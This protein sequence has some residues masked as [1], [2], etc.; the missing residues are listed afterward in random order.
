M[1]GGPPHKGTLLRPGT[2]ESIDAQ[3][4][5]YNRIVAEICRGIAEAAKLNAGPS[6][7]PGW[8]AVDCPDPASADWLARAVTMENVSA[9]CE[10]KILFLPAGPAYRIEKEVK[11][12]VT[13]IAKTCHYWFDHTSASHRAEIAELTAAMSR[14]APL[15][16]PGWNSASEDW[17]PAPMPSVAT[18]IWMMRAVVACN[19]LARREGTT[20]LVAR[21]SAIDPADAR[22]TAVL[23]QLSVYAL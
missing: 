3:P 18:A 6:L 5:G 2:P 7:H 23:E 1:A 16:Q 19:V 8:I 21:N 4:Q 15:L 22:A 13:S 11:N 17:I 20:L 10:G 12:V 9:R 14:I